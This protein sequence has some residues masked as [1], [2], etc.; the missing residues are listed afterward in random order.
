MS[1]EYSED[2]LVQQTT[3]QF[4]AGALDWE[5]AFAHNEEILGPDGTFGRLSENEVVL[6][7]YLRQALEEF[8]P[9]L[10]ETVYSQAVTLITASS[11]AKSLVQLNQEKYTL[12]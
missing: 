5:S 6:K 2:R 1:R 8:N 10:P 4:L 12:Y 11:T 9:G 3:A 7:C